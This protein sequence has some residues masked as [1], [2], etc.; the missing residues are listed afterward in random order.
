MGMN[1]IITRG[2]DEKKADDGI[3]DADKYSANII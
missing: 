1:S 2:Q 3:S